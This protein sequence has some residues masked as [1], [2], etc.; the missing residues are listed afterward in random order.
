MFPHA[1]ALLDVVALLADI[2]EKN[3]VRGQVGTVVEVYDDGAVEVEFCHDDGRLYALVT[4]RP[5][6][7]MRLH[8]RPAKVA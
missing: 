6:Q 8:Y 3:L 5:S 4:L 2:P 1:F 7:L